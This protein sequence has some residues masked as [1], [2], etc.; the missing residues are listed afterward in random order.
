MLRVGLCSP[1]PDRGGPRERG[2]VLLL[3]PSSVVVILV[4][5]AIVLDFGLAH[6]RIQELRAVAASAANDAIGG[7]DA[8]ALRTTGD[9]VFDLDIAENLAEAAVAAGPLPDAEVESV[10][11]TRDAQNRWEI[12]VTVSVTVEHAIAPA[13]PGSNRSL[14]AEV[15]ERVLAAP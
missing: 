14:R 2:T 12:A 9:I 7:L 8:D 1:P 15:T 4:L 3:F 13:L 5:A 6:V 10:S 11:I